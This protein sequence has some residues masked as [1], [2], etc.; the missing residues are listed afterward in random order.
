VT[1][2]TYGSD[3]AAYAEAVTTLLDLIDRHAGTGGARAAAQVLLSCYNSGDYHLA[4]VDIRTLSSNAHRNAALTVIVQRVLRPEEPH[5]VVPD[6]E[7]RFRALWDEYE[8][9]LHVESRYRD[10]YRER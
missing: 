7:R 10:R 9:E 2:P 4:P 6:G 3:R 1:I 5:Q 8:D